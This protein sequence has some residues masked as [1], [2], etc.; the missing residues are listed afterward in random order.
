[1]LSYQNQ[2]NS[3][4]Y[5]LFKDWCLKNGFGDVINCKS[6]NVNMRRLGQA[7]NQYIP[8]KRELRGIAGYPMRVRGG[9]A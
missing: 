6:E 2:I 4:P 5:Q 7:I 8:P 9:R 3:D 1:M